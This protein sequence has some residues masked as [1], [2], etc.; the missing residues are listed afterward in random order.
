MAVYLLN[1]NLVFPHP[2]SAEPSGLLAVGGDLSVE[3]LLLAYKSGIFPWY[4]EGDPIL[5]FSPDPRMVLFPDNLYVTKGLKKI[6]KSG[7]YDVRFDTCF[8]DVIK[9]CSSQPRNGQDNTWITAEMIDAYV[10]LHNQGYAHSVEV[11][12]NDS[13]V[14]G[15]YG[16]SIGGTFFGESMFHEL[17]NVSKIALYSLVERTRL[18]G[19]EFIDSQV[20]NDHMKSMGC[21]EIP[22]SEFLELLERALDKKTIQGNWGDM[23]IVQ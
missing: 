3:R 12:H 22:R 23:D 8:G 1:D 2:A 14:G 9:K 15:L 6:I 7:K 21:K 4:S 11:F 16:V 17:S 5:W 10:E 13:L 20:P 18:W 19:F